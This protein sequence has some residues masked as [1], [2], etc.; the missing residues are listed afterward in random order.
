M[1]CSK[2]VEQYMLFKSASE[3]KPC[4]MFSM[5]HLILLVITTACIITAIE[6]TKNMKKDQ[7]KEVIKK[8]T[9]FLWILEIIKIIFN[10]INYGVTA[11]NK[12]VPLYFC[13][14]IL[15]AG[16]FSGFCKGVLKKVGDVF[17]STGG[18]IA[19]IIFLISPL[20]S[21]TTY[22][23]IHFISIHSFVLHG[24]MVYIGILML[25]TKYV[26]IEKKDIIYYSAIIIAISAIAYIVNIV[27]DSNLMFISQ[28]YPGTFIE[29]IYNVTGK[30]FPIVMVLAQATLPFYIVYGIYSIVKNKKQI[31]ISNDTYNEEEEKEE[32]Y[33]H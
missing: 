23:A 17:L 3:V 16:I 21:L 33:M 12:Y 5:Q 22:P 15:Y 27:C 20:T 8:A 13:S 29:I 18:I 25:I 14:L 11:V 24:T 2:E 30:L 26:T 9:I 31:N 1:I 32:I 28:N 6:Q 19:G 7:V 10:I 4:G